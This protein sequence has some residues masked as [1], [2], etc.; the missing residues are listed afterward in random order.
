MDERAAKVSWETFWSRVDR[1]T[2]GCWQWT[3]FINPNGYSQMS[4][5]VDGK[6]RT[7]QAH[8]VAYEWFVGPVPDG[9]TIDHLCRNT[10]CV[11]PAHLEAVAH[12]E[13]VRRAVLA[14]DMAPASPGLGERIRTYRLAHRLTAAD[15]ARLLG[16]C[17][18]SAVVQ[19][20]T[21]RRP[22]MSHHGARIDALL[23]EGEA[24][25]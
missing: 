14:R 9:L 12:H 3:G 5:R 25:A 7:I 15:F 8:R 11:N 20:E 1:Q 10:R 22:R 19:W 13:N 16:G 6:V 4:V 18:A 17:D 24:A 2:D 21:G 23:S